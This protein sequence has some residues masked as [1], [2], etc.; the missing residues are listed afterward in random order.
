MDEE[1]TCHI[2][3]PPGGCRTERGSFCFV[4][5]LGIR[6]GPYIQQVGDDLSGSAYRSRVQG[7]GAICI[8]TVGVGARANQCSHNADP[9]ELRCLNQSS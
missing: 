9:I 2:D 8:G 5:T 3:V 4:K 7:R 1:L 6:G